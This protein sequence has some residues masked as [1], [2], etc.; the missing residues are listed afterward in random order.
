M[1][2]YD[3]EACNSLAPIPAGK[4]LPNYSVV[5]L[6]KNL[7]AIPIG[8]PGEVLIGGAGPARGYLNNEELAKKKFIA[9]MYAP[10]EYIAKGWT[11]AYC[12]GDRGRL[13]ADGALLF[14][15]RIDG[16]S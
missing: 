7:K 5:I 8:V 16:D 4:C 3:A 1:V 2:P 15:G 13:R 11:T 10:P 9:N 12:S 14:D 6:D